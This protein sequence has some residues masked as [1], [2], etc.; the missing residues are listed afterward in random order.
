MPRL[1][2]LIF[3]LL[4]VASPA[5]SLRFFASPFEV[6]EGDAVV[7]NYIEADRSAGLPTVKLSQITSWKW[8]FDGDGI[9]DEEH[10]VG[11]LDPNTGLP[12]TVAAINATWNS[13]IT[14]G[15]TIQNLSPRLQATFTDGSGS[16]PRT[17]S[18][19]TED[20]FGTDGGT[21]PTGVDPYVTVKNRAVGNPDLTVNFSVNPRLALT[22]DT[23]RFYSSVTPAD[24][25][26]LSNLTYSW[27]FTNRSTN[28]TVTSSVASP[29]L[30]SLAGSTNGTIYDVILTVGY[31]ATYVDSTGKTQ[32]TNNSAGLALTKKDS[33]RVIT[34]PNELQLGRAYR[35]GF[36]ATYGWDDIVKAYS[37]LGA[38]N[39]DHVYFHHLENAFFSQQTALLANPMDAVKRQTMAEIV[40]EL[41]QGQTMVAN[42]GL[43]SA[44]RIKY[45]RLSGDVDPNNPSSRM[46]A[47]A[48]A[49]TE[50][51]AIDSAILDYSLAV[52]YSAAAIKDYG[53][54]ILRSK[55][56]DGAEPFPQFPLYLS[57]TDPTLSHDAPIP[58]KNEYWQLTSA[59]E[60]MEL[61]RVEKAKKLWRLSSQDSTALPEAKAECK[62]AGTQAYLAMALLA[63]G[64]T[65]TSYQA[66]EGNLLLAHVK[67]ARDLF[68]NIN[69]GVNPLGNDGSFIPNE[70]FTA[71]YQDASDAVTEA[72]SE[73][74]SARQETRTFQQYQAEQRNELQS[75]RAQFITPLYNLTG[76][77]PGAYND[78]KTIDDRNDYKQTIN[79][80]IQALLA[81]YPKAT[82]S[83]LGDL[84]SQVIAIL[85][86]GDG[87]KQA[88]N[89]LNNLAASIEISK[90][91][92][93]Q[94]G[95][96]NGS[97]TSLLKANDIAR[98]YASAWSIT[99][100]ASLTYTF[101]GSNTGLSASAGISATY[102][103]GAL[104]LANLNANDRDIQT[105]QQASIADIQ[106]EA[107]T[108]KS[109]LE[110]ANLGIDI[111]RAN[112]Q[113]DQQRLKLEQMV[114]LMDRYIEDLAHAR[115]TAAPLYFQDPTFQVVVSTA[116]QRAENQLDYTVDKLYR[117]AKTL[118]YEWT[119]G[120]KNPVIV[121]ANSQEPA[122]LSN[123]LFDK[124]T[125]TDS[126]F[127]IR[128]ADEAYDYLSALKAW[129]S[130]LR[131]INVVSVR[132]PNHSAPI[133]AEPISMRETI[134]GMKPDA[135]R[136]YTLDNS[137]G[138]QNS[139]NLLEARRAG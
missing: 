44:L 7:F 6:Y 61:G 10:S 91:A 119:E 74:I 5:Q 62:T 106:L 81:N 86:A 31:T 27:Q 109:L 95:L 20:V 85:D 53:S 102:N 101:T 52:Q 88:I 46:N 3:L 60:R 2:G 65:E 111:R 113:L 1:A 122:S 104:T 131:G 22:T 123:P 132:G 136:G 80:Y 97:T 133:S 75:Q 108:R 79:G 15:T 118:E 29:S 78:L 43:I 58:I 134:L 121:P 40:N 28:S 110:V 82:A 72:R 51:A 103:P 73:Q 16:H 124:F 92:N 11:D 47:P 105:L 129:D 26:T 89:R 39:D 115:A 4:T 90:W 37:A 84:G 135:T 25:R 87:I 49:R 137:G 14:D 32:T 8:D 120:Y 138:V 94:V 17:Q 93:T 98:G 107:E 13:R 71:I 56:P 70:S 114:S 57:F 36:P 68:E 59:F 41:Q 42:Q 48:G 96:V 54:D 35:Q 116:M 23:I 83:G 30:T 12:I 9:W 45:P 67:N 128:T 38:G 77:D 21:Y 50:T 34:V 99:A 18:G 33:F 100:S 19:V 127:F 112:N 64:Q 24:G 130:K 66:N 63:A 117:L 55:A 139:V 69:A 126:L 76:L 125:N